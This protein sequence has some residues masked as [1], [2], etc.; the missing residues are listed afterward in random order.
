ME[1]GVLEWL[2]EGILKRNNLKLKNNKK[3][4]FFVQHKKYLST[5]IQIVILSDHINFNLCKNDHLFN[6]L[7]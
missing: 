5:Q 3:H 4:L 1:I 6:V 7:K 2:G